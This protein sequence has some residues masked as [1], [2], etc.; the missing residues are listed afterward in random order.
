MTKERP[1]R[2][3]RG[4]AICFWLLALSNFAKPLQL[5]EH[6][7]FVLFGTRLTGGDSVLWSLVFGV[8][9]VVYGLG[10][11]YMKRIVI[12][13]AHAYALYVVVNLFLYWSRNPPPSGADV[14]LAVLY[15]LIAVGVSLGSAVLLSKHR[16]ELG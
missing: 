15:S 4:L 2:V 11:W 9:L 6:S 16:K 13:M 14:V 1:D 12:G 8:Y 3:F 5:T 7:G 10:L